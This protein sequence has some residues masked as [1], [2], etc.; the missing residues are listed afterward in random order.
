MKKYPFRLEDEDSLVLVDCKIGPG[1]YALALDTG[2]SHT[3]IDITPLLMIG[4]DPS[5]ALKAV[6]FETANGVVSASVFFVPHFSALGHTIRD[7]EIC[8]YDFL[9]NGVVSDFDGMLGLD[10]LKSKD[11]LVSFKR[12]EI[13]LT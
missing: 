5:Q 7:F 9:A 8:A 3:I 6:E 13:S 10:F 12:L 11:L 2:A 4:I 1:N